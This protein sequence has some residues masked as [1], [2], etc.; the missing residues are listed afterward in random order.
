VIATNGLMAGGLR[1][2]L[3]DAKSHLPA[4]IVWRK[5]VARPSLFQSSESQDA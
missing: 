1:L 3:G 5:Q 2:A 4:C